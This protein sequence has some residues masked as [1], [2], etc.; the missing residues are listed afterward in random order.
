ML[1]VANTVIMFIVMKNVHMVKKIVKKCNYI[2]EVGKEKSVMCEARY[3]YE[4]NRKNSI[5]L[6]HKICWYTQHERESFTVNMN[7]TKSKENA[8]KRF[9]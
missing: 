7:Q 6:Q 9:M 8:K 4:K 1:C 5:C 2:F 3:V